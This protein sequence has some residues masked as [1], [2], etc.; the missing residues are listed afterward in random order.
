MS[1]DQA[2]AVIKGPSGTTVTLV[3]QRNGQNFTKT[4][5]RSKVQV[6]FVT[7]KKLANNEA[8]V[9]IYMFGFGLGSEFDKV[10]EQIQN[11]PSIKSIIIDLRNNPGGS[12]EEAGNVLKYFVPRDQPSV[13]TKYQD[14]E[15]RMYSP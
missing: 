14:R 13:L 10:A 6:Q 12:L 7:W 3:I 4:I 1:L 5:T 11:D 2:I 9:K 8:Y 15:E